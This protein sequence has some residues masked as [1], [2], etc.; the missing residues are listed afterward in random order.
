MG[1]YLNNSR[2]N[3][4][5]RSHHQKMIKKFG[6]VRNIIKAFSQATK[7]KKESEDDLRAPTDDSVEALA[8]EKNSFSSP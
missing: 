5:C 6:K 3:E 8:S 7:D 2:N 4:Q 1:E